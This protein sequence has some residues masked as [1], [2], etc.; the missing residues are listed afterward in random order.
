MARNQEKA[1]TM[2]NRFLKGK[3][4]KLYLDQQKKPLSL[5]D[6]SNLEKAHSSHTKIVQTIARKIGE[7]QSKNLGE[8]RIRELNDEI[9]KLNKERLNWEQRKEELGGPN[10]MIAITNT[11]QHT[12]LTSKSNYLYYGAAHDLP[13]VKDLSDSCFNHELAKLTI[14]NRLKNHVGVLYYGLS[15]DKS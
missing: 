8:K 6:A 2:L 4:A 12:P 9:N 11:N 10:H 3:K 7:I 15:D 13:G 14:N 5:A 1:Q